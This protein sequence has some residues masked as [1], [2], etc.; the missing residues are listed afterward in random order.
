MKYLFKH[1]GKVTEA[2][3]YTQKIEAVRAYV[4]GQTNQAMSRF[5]LFTSKAQGNQSFSSW[6]TKVC[7]QAEKC[8]FNGYT[9]EKAARDAIIFQTS[10]TKLRKKALAEDTDLD[11]L[12]KLGLA[13]K[14]TAVNC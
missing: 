9:K 1:I 5:K 11:E 3:T 13:N 14:H 12:V 4:T 7:E 2:M 6:W 10:D 8:D